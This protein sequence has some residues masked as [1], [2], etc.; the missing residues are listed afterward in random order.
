MSDL[1]THYIEVRYVYKTFDRP[2][3]VDIK[4][5]VFERLRTESVQ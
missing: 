5:L 1:F 4:F 3:L 2:V